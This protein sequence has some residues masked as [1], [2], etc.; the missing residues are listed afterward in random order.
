MHSNLTDCHAI[1]LQISPEHHLPYSTLCVFTPI[2]SLALWMA[3]PSK[4]PTSRA[5]LNLHVFN[6]QCKFFFSFLLYYNKCV[7]S[8][9]LAL[10][11]THSFKICI[12]CPCAHKVK[13]FRFYQLGGLF[14]I[15]PTQKQ[16]FGVF[17][18]GR[19]GVL[20][21]PRCPSCCAMTASNCAF[22][23]IIHNQ[24]NLFK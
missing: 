1:S 13:I 24:E 8:H 11:T 15:V 17:L 16:G 14:L 2:T 9:H 4:Q 21:W 10:L 6:V 20:M 3:T 7:F 23:T 22:I 12:L 18:T 5:S 19:T